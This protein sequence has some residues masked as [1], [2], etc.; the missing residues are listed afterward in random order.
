L[1]AGTAPDSVIAV[2]PTQLYETFMGFI[3]FAVLWRFRAHHQRE[4]WLFGMYCVL[5]GVERFIVEFFRAK[6]DTVSVIGLTS[7]QV[8]ALTVL[9]IGV[10]IMAWR[11][12]PDAGAPSRG[13]ATA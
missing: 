9:T 11:R 1:P 5:A 2:H 4:G 10:A 3:M 6:D 13:T 8:V 7:A 12:N